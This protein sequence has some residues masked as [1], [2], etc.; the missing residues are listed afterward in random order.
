MFSCLVVVAVVAADLAAD[1][2]VVFVVAADVFVVFVV[3]VVVQEE[4]ASKQ[5]EQALL[6]VAAPC[7]GGASIA[8]PSSVG[9]S[10]VGL[11][12]LLLLVLLRLVPLLL[13]SSAGPAPAHWLAR[14]PHLVGF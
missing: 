8:G 3:A 11:S 5:E 13:A 6:S 12:V 4:Q 7:V 14:W 2:F 1:V 10:S 9:P